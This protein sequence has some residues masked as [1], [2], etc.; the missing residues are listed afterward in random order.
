MASETKDVVFHGKLRQTRDG[1][2][3]VDVPNSIFDGF[4]PMLGGEA[5]KPPK[6]ERHYDDI[7]AHITVIKKKEVEENK[8]QFKDN[9]KIIKYIINGVEKVENPDG[10]DEMAAVWFISVTAPELE[11]IRTSY[12]LSPKIKDHDF[13]ITLGVKRKPLEDNTLV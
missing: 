1:F 4:L 2:I 6:N 7:G 3:Y 8:I 10:W 11:K 9:G 5:E 13:H 12:G